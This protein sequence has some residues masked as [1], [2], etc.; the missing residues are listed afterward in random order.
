MNGAFRI[1]NEHVKKVIELTIKPNNE[2]VSIEFLYSCNDSRDYSRKLERAY[3]N[4]HRQ[5]RRN[6]YKEFNNSQNEFIVE[7]YESFI[8]RFQDG[9]YLMD[10]GKEININEYLGY[11]HYKI[12]EEND[13]I[14][15]LI[16]LGAL[17]YHN[18][19]LLSKYE[20]AKKEIETLETKFVKLFSSGIAISLFFDALNDL[21][22]LDSETF[23]GEPTELLGIVHAVIEHDL[24]IDKLNSNYS[25][26]T[27]LR[28]IAIRLN[29]IRRITDQETGKLKR[30][31]PKYSKF[32]TAKEAMADKLKRLDSK[33]R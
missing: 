12:I 15:F 27:F 4:R 20:T 32:F 14:D 21:G 17:N 29:Y 5:A 33:L 2:T 13:L 9:Y 30:I 31:E 28:I 25:T 10:S 19:F 1:L 3:V 11:C 22:F 24:L 26:P 8:S 7:E 18:D 6:N 16:L 23:K